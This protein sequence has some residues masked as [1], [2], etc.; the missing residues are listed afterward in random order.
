MVEK[1]VQKAKKKKNKNNAESKLQIK[2]W[3]NPAP[4]YIFVFLWYIYPKRGI[5][6]LEVIGMGF[7]DLP[8]GANSKKDLSATKKP[9]DQ[10]ASAV[11]NSP[12]QQESLTNTK[13][14]Q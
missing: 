10:Q 12:N 13:P 9:T 8:G 4:F 11:S 14:S 2:G 1:F 5:L 7:K 6:K 3:E